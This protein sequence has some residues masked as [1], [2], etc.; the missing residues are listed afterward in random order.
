MEETDIQR[1]FREW[2]EEQRDRELARAVRSLLREHYGKSAGWCTAAVRE[3]IEA[4]EELTAYLRSVAVEGDDA[5]EEEVERV[6]R[7]QM[8]RW[9]TARR[10]G[11]KP[12]AAPG[13][14]L[15]AILD[16]LPTWREWGRMLIDAGQAPQPPLH[17]NQGARR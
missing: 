4:D 2:R 7:Q 1:A 16:L 13:P 17:P 10:E 11:R 5:W 9:R 12:Q 6:R 8:R 14:S 15:M 3:A